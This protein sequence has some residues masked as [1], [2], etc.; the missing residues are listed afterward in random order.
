M[1]AHS[2]SVAKIVR[3]FAVEEDAVGGLG[4]YS[5]APQIRWRQT[6]GQLLELE[7]GRER[8]GRR[9]LVLQAID[10]AGGRDPSRH[11][12]PEDHAAGVDQV[13][14]PIDEMPVAGGLLQ[15]PIDVADLRDC[16]G[17][18][19]PGPH[20][21]SQSSAAGGGWGVGSFVPAV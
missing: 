15:P 6:T 3:L 18:S 13:D 2:D 11:A 17:S 16:R 10:P 9:D 20:Q 4:R 14:A 5:S 21:R 19:G 7:V 12:Q 1:T 8:V